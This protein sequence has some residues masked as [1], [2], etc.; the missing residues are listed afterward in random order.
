MTN[1]VLMIR[2]TRQCS[3]LETMQCDR[4]LWTEFE[5]LLRARPGGLK[6]EKRVN[7]CSLGNAPVVKSKAVILFLKDN[8][9][10]KALGSCGPS[11]GGFTADPTPLACDDIFI[12]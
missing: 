9:L 2:N 1:Q 7:C 6:T 4:R 11:Y 3:V 5:A 8:F 10:S 12:F